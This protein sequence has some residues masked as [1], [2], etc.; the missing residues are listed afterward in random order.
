[1][2]SDSRPLT[3]IHAARVGVVELWP[4]PEHMSCHRCKGDIYRTCPDFTHSDRAPRDAE[5]GVL[6]AIDPRPMATP[7][8]ALGVSIGAPGTN[9]NRS[10]TPS[11]RLVISIIMTMLVLMP[12][13]IEKSSHQS[14]VISGA[15]TT[16]LHHNA[17][18]DDERLKTE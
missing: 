1:M 17:G 7:D 14:H 15:C 12:S 2:D 16:D 5:A 11:A 6:H 3:K 9:V 18:V 10:S 8:L 13:E 4:A